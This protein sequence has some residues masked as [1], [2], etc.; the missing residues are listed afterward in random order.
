M[1]Y[2]ILLLL[3]N[4]EIDNQLNLSIYIIIIIT[5]SSNVL[6]LYM[7]EVIKKLKNTIKICKINMNLLIYSY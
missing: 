1:H 5:E 7:N 3:F 6:V 4:N 2:K